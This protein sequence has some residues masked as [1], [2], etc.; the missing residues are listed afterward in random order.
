MTWRLISICCCRP[1]QQ[2]AALVP[3]GV[4]C[5]KSAERK[6]LPFQLIKPYQFP[7]VHD[8]TLQ[9]L[10]ECSAGKIS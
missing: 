9:R 3:H 1:V 2:A 8:I 7:H 5:S 6:Q 4:G 10:W